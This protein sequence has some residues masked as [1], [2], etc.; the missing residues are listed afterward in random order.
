MAVA[1]EH[2]ES[3]P[4]QEALHRRR[5]PAVG[6]G[7]PSFGL[8]LGLQRSAGNAA[9]ARHFSRSQH[10][11]VASRQIA[12]V[13]VQRCGPVACDCSAEERADYAEKH[14]E[15]GSPD[16]ETDEA[17]STPTAPVQR[18]AVPGSDSQ[19]EAAESSGAIGFRRRALDPLAL[20]QRCGCSE[21]PSNT[22]ALPV[23]AV[24][25]GRSRSPVGEAMT[26]IDAATRKVR[27]DEP[28]IDTVEKGLRAAQAAEVPVDLDGAAQSPP[29]SALAVMRTGFG[30]ESVPARKPVPSPKPVPAVSPLGR[31]AAAPS[32]AGGRGRPGNAEGATY[33]KSEEDERVQTKEKPGHTPELN[34]HAESQITS[35]RG[36]VSPFS[37]QRSPDQPAG[38]CGLCYGEGPGK[39]GPRDAGLAAHKAIQNELAPRGITDELPWGNGKIDLAVVRPPPV[40]QIAIAEIKPANERGIDDGIK[41]IEARL[42]LRPKL[43]EYAGYKW[44]KLNEPVE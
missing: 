21:D 31:A 28:A 6:T 26:A 20:V 36:V 12:A 44:V 35:R 4:A 7:N 30:P 42:R 15:E 18:H 17:N 22:A 13:Q 9:V 41:Q 19:F 40:K 25:A 16:S 2:L 10:S 24:L 3:Q 8:I 33:P 39:V 37:I 29:A 34:L 32:K 11:A 14:P 27:P 23:S 5:S 43:R 1:L 38:G